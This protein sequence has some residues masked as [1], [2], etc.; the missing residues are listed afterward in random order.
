MH[1][2][3]VSRMYACLLAVMIG[4]A[5]AVCGTEVFE[6]AVKVHADDLA[7]FQPRF[8]VEKA[9]TADI[10]GSLVE[11]GDTSAGS[12]TAHFFNLGQ[13]ITANVDRV[14]SGG[15]VVETQY[16]HG[17][18]G[19]WIALAS[20]TFILD[21]HEPN[22][23]M[24][25]VAADGRRF[26][27]SVALTPRHDIL[28]L[29]DMRANDPCGG[30]PIDEGLLQKFGPEPGPYNHHCTRCS[31]DNGNIMVCCNAC[32]EDP[33]SC[34]PGAWCCAPGHTPPIP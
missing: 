27:I 19:A 3:D 13:R 1:F 25:L 5:P 12:R 20:P 33:V 32:C 17:K 28:T 8:L 22:A 26:V 6:V 14:A 11:A 2:V 24:D 15:F 23:S 30:C 29:D 4:V 10:R 18:R 31:C 34:P 7:V 16:S 9:Q 21:E